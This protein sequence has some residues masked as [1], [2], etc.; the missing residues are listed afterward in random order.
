M[1][2]G[3]IKGWTFRLVALAAGLAFLSACGSS[4]N[5][6][7][8]AAMK[9]EAQPLVHFPAHSIQQCLARH[10]ARQAENVIELNFLAKAEKEDD[11]SKPGFAYDKTMSIVVHVWTGS[12][13]EGRPAPWM[14]W[15]GQPFGKDRTPQEIVAEK[16]KK[17]Y[18]MYVRSSK[19]R[20]SAA[21]CI[22]FGK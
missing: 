16:P 11:V 4:Q 6:Q 5:E 18:V 14:I 20:K 8:T 13:F 3:R 17:S 22:T 2:F 10:G 19:Q 1:R 9:Q 15:V 7:A 12:S 21:S